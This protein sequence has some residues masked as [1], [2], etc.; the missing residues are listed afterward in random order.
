MTRMTDRHRFV[1]DALARGPQTKSEL[2]R[3]LH[4]SDAA[5]RKT[6]QQLR[7]F[8]YGVTFAD[9]Y[10]ALDSVNEGWDDVA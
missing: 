4:S 6:L 1:L 8:G 2:R 3:A 5:L 9:G 10:Y 7:G